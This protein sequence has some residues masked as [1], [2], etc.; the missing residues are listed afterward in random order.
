MN[1]IRTLLNKYKY[2][3]GI[4]NIRILVD[5]HTT[6]LSTVWGQEIIEVY[7]MGIYMGDDVEIPY[8]RIQEIYDGTS[9]LY[10]KS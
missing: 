5:N 9:L 1:P 7:P 8:H 2:A 3:G 4:N 6:E 10:R